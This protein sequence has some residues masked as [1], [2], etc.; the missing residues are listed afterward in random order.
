MAIEGPLRELGIHDVFQ[1]L[2]LSKK[3]GVLSVSSTLR[4]NDGA[5]FFD[6]GAVVGAEIK[7][8]PH[9]LG[10]MLVSSG[11][12]TQG[13]LERALQQQAKG[14]GERLGEVLL[15]LGF[16]TERELA[17]H[18]RRQIEEVVFEVLGWREGYF[19]FAEGPLPS[20]T[21]G[22]GVRIAAGALLMEGA[23]RIDEWSRME[24]KIPHLGMV[25]ALAPASSGAE[26]DVALNP[27]EW[28]LLAAVDGERDLRALAQALGRSEFDVAKTVFGMASAG[29]L[30]LLD[31][32]TRPSRDAPAP[33]NAFDR[34]SEALAAGDVEGARAAA[35]AAAA[36]N[37]REPLVQWLLGRVALAA[38]RPAEGEE[39]LRRAL[40]LDP[41]SAPAHRALADAL[42]LQG[43]HAEAVNWWRRWLALDDPART[44]EE[45]EQIQ[46]T[47]RAAQ[48]LDS[49]L[50]MPHA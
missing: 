16:L 35:Q 32:G 2:D 1:L 25:P 45:R 29:V 43:K 44:N 17:D 46:E 6:T 42:A 23:R 26:G 24:R 31:P 40:Q 28:D 11:K 4:R 41:L 37:P 27:L 15:A 5:V 21:G 38:G 22:G 18:V 33:A 20:S 7:S 49:L 13:E 30:V 10:Q 47:V 8:N 9:Q 12:I 48:T 14:Q 34:A 36:L 50:R 3:T 39:Y 19:S